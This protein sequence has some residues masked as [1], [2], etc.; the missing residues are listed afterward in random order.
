ML[1]F[2]DINASVCVYVYVCVC[3]WCTILGC[4]WQHCN[5]GGEA[6]TALLSCREYTII[7][8]GFSEQPGENHIGRYIALY[9]NKGK[10]NTEDLTNNKSITSETSCW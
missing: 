7:R 1:F 10:Y 2:V 8:E 9:K 5:Q 6:Q 4:D 3:V